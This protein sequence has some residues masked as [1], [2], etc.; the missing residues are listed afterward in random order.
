MH[1]IV[2]IMAITAL[3]AATPARALCQLRS[4]AECLASL[5]ERAVPIN[6][7]LFADF[8]SPDGDTLTATSV[9][10]DDVVLFTPIQ[11]DGFVRIEGEREL[12]PATDYSLCSNGVFDT[13]ASFRTS[14]ERD[15]VPPDAPVASL[16]RTEGFFREPECGGPWSGTVVVILADA[17]EDVGAMSLRR[18]LFA[19]TTTT[20]RVEQATQGEE[21]GLID[22]AEE[23]GTARYEIV[24]FD[25]AGNASEPTLVEASLGCPGSCAQTSGVPLGV[26]L[27]ALL[28]VRRA[29]KT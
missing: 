28:L 21:V 25:L 22:S 16:D 1:R 5:D 15:D 10:G 14:N 26:T 3:A 24:A 18:T 12:Q 11:Q 13:C 19:G 8:A 4:A 9:D 17:V 6:L 23:G 29:R 20:Q 7:V 2:L 27:A